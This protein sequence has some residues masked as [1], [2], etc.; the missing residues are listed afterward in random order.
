MEL[1]RNQNGTETKHQGSVNHGR[2]QRQITKAL[3]KHK[4]KNKLNMYIGMQI[5]STYCTIVIAHTQN[6]KRFIFKDTQRPSLST[7]GD[8]FESLNIPI[9]TSVLEEFFQS[10]YDSVQT[11]TSNR[12]SLIL[13]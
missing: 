6:G 8:V 5:L 2:E 3:F 13:S 7:E 1:L 11:A 9:H 12:A 10:P 4:T